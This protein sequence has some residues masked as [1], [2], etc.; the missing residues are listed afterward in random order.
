MIIININQVINYI[1]RKIDELDNEIT[2]Y[3]EKMDQCVCFTKKYWLYHDK[4][5]VAFIEKTCLADLL[6][7]I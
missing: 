5:E 6:E 7:H 4:Y 2:E 1:S 3:K